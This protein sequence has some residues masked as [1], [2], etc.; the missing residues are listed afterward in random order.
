MTQ[1][2]VPL[3]CVFHLAEEVIMKDAETYRNYAA[4]CIRMANLLRDNDRD[5]LLKMAEAW[6]ERAKEAENRGKKSDR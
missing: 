4:D 6:E 3:S 2:K 5:A 1:N